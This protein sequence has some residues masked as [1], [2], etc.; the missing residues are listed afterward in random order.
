MYFLHFVLYCFVFISHHHSAE[1][2]GVKKNMP[3]YLDPDLKDDDLL[4]GVSFGSGASGF[5]PLTARL[6]VSSL[7]MISF[8]L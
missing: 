5:D 1:A 2:L 7:E 4:T 8:S 3:A 6:L